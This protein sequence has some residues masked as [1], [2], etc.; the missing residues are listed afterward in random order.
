MKRLNHARVHPASLAAVMLAASVSIVLRAGDRGPD[1]SRHQWPESRPQH[2]PLD[3]HDVRLEPR[4]RR[5][6]HQRGVLRAVE[7]RDGRELQSDQTTRAV[8]VRGF[9]ERRRTT[10]RRACTTREFSY[11]PPFLRGGLRRP[12][13]TTGG[14][15][16]ASPLTRDMLV[17]VSS[18]DNPTHPWKAMSC[19]RCR[20]RRSSSTTSRSGLTR[21]ACTSRRWFS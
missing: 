6:L 20:T 21:T 8:L 2:S 11:R 12:M 10:Q 14:D 18:D 7:D 4:L 9:Q 17:A 3:G 15:A 5:R 1:L 19:T 13:R 16:G